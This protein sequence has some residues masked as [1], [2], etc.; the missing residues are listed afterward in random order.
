MYKVF[1]LIGKSSA[2]DAYFLRP[3]ELILM[4]QGEKSSNAEMNCHIVLA[5]LICLSE[6][7]ESSKSSYSY[8]KPGECKETVDANECFALNSRK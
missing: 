2:H 6:L 3:Q 5:V 4:T 8:S 1:V 7:R